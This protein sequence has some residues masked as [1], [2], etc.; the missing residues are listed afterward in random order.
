MSEGNDS[1]WDPDDDLSSSSICDTE[2]WSDKETLEAFSELRGVS[3]SSK[4]EHI[5]KH[6]TDSTVGFDDHTIA[7]P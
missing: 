5:I 4:Q 3:E 2:E 1:D 6:F 7:I